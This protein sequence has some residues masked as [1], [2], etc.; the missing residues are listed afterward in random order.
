MREED[1][2][3][4]D[5]QGCQL[6]KK[7]FALRHSE[8]EISK[9]GPVK[10]RKVLQ[11]AQ[12]PDPEAS[13]VG[14]LT[15]EAGPWRAQLSGL[16]ASVSVIRCV[17]EVAFSAPCAL[18]RARAGAQA[19]RQEVSRGLCF[20][21]ERAQETEEAMFLVFTCSGQ[22]PAQPTDLFRMTA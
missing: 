6:T 11:E 22:P 5:S 17:R 8:C 1:S 4:C 16:E 20:V 3:G 9:T 18:C 14:G 15:T 7:A 10:L 13:A 21:L 19:W 12:S 2:K